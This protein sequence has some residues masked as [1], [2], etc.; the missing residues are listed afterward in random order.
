[1]KVNPNK[2]QVLGYSTTGGIEGTRAMAMGSA[3]RKE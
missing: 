3:F 2:E 1:M